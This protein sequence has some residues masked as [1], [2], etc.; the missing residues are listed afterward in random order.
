M[1]FVL[2]HFIDEITFLLLGFWQ[3]LT[4]KPQVCVYQYYYFNYFL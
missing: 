2:S 4:I 3:W 1:N